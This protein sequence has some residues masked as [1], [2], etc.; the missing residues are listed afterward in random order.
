M[1]NNF[2]NIAVLIDADNISEK[3]VK[4]IFER[5]AVF[6]EISIRRIYGDW[7]SDGMRSWKQSLQVFSIQP[8]QQFNNAKGKNSTDSA[9]IIDA[10]DLLYKDFFDC[11][12]II[13]SDSD[14]TRL[15]QRIRE[16]GKYVIGIGEKKT[17]EAFVNGCNEFL[18]LEPTKIIAETETGNKIK[19]NISIHETIDN[20]VDTLAD[21]SGWVHLSKLMQYI[22][23]VKPNFELKS[24]DVKKPI[25]YFLKKNTVYIIRYENENGPGSVFISKKK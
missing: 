7:T 4:E 24:L 22:R 9:L 17:P 19:S 3:H 2:S 1:N 16:Q 6:G 14:F 20:A 15:A 10:M 8:I 13:S 18:Y 5:V 23:Q 21:S 25:D 12:C 11:F